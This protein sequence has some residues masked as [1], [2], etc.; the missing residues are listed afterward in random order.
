MICGG[1]AVVAAILDTPYTFCN[2]KVPNIRSA[3][4][5]LYKVFHGNGLS[6]E[7]QKLSL[8]WVLLNCALSNVNF[9]RR[10]SIFGRHNTF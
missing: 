10:A 7:T 5:F 2:E 9:V 1:E 8:R 6:D 3:A 4:V